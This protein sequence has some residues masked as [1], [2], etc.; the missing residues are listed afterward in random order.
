ML[1][2]FCYTKFSIEWL[3]YFTIELILISFF[4]ISIYNVIRFEVYHDEDLSLR[5]SLNLA[6]E[7]MIIF[8]GFFIFYITKNKGKVTELQQCFCK[9]LS[10][11]LILTGITAIVA[12]SRRLKNSEST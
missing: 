9:H 11:F 4:I 1:I 12:T 8:I 7:C 5:N 3:V 10:P 6:I 2:S